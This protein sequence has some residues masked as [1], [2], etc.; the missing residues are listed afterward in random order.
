MRMMNPEKIRLARI[1]T[2]LKVSQKTG[3]HIL[4][5]CNGKGK[6]NSLINAI[7][8]TL[9]LFANTIPSRILYFRKEIKLLLGKQEKGNTTFQCQSTSGA[10]S[11]SKILS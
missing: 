5:L 11:G 3:R 4:N 2:I 6:E 10:C 9:L 8:C 1:G 7:E